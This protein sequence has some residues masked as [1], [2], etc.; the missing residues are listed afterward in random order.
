MLVPDLGISVLG[1]LT[2]AIAEPL[3]AGRDYVAMGWPTGRDGRKC[4]AATVIVDLE[5]REMA[6][7]DATW[8]EVKAPPADGS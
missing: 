6:R 5:G 3:E 8:I 4:H 7:S 1:R 2:S